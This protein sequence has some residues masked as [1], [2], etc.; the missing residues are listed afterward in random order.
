MS[1][2][3]AHDFSAF[4]RIAGSGCSGVDLLRLAGTPNLAVAAS[5]RRRATAGVDRGD[6]RFTRVRRYLRIAAGMAG[7]APAW[8]AGRP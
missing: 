3:D 8:G 5:V 1:F 2:V 7:V 6:P 4:S